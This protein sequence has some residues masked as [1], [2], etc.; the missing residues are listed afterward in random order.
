MRVNRYHAAIN[1][2]AVTKSISVRV[3]IQCT[4]YRTR[5]NIHCLPAIITINKLI[6]IRVIIGSIRLS[7]ISLTIVVNILTKSI[8]QIVAV[9]ISFK[10]CVIDGSIGIGTE[11]SQIGA[12]RSNRA[13]K[14]KLCPILK[15]IKIGRS[16]CG[17]R[18]SRI[19]T[20]I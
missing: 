7:S 1:L 20:N 5:P 19:S 6:T 2:C 4:C 3:K 8:D 15:A 13:T 16:Q 17:L 10:Q 9:S 11:D 18:H 12:R 14:A